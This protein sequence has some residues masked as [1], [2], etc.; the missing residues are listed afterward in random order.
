M[1]GIDY[2]VS[3]GITEDDIKAYVARRDLVSF[4]KFMDVDLELTHFHLVYYAVLNMFAQGK[5]RKLIISAPPQH[6]K[7]EGSTRKLPA[8]LL[9]MNPDEKIAIGSYE[10]TTAQDFNKDVQK[11][12]DSDEYR[13]VFPETR[14]SRGEGMSYNSAFARNSRV[15]EIVGRKGKLMAVGRSRALTSKTVDTSILDDI[16]KDYEEGNSPII[17]EKAWKWYTSVIRK[18]LHN[19]SRELIVF[20][21]WHD[22]DIIGRLE[23]IETVIVP[24][25]W[26]DFDNIPEGA[27]IK[28]NFQAIK[29]DEWSELDPRSQGEALW[30]DRHSIDKLL[31]ERNLD[32]VQFEC[33]NQGNTES[34]ESL[35]YSPFKTYHNSEELGVCIGKGNYT[36]TADEGDDKLCSISYDKIR[37]V[38]EFGKRTYLLAVTDIL[39]TDE[40][41]EK[42][43]RLMPVLYKN[44]DTRYSRIESNN[45]GKAFALIIK[46][47]CKHV[48]ITWFHQSKNKE[49]RI[50]TNAGL[51]NHHIIMPYGWECKWPEFYKVVVRYKR[52][53]SANKYHDASDV[54][55]G[56]IEKEILQEGLR[57]GIRR[58]N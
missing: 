21:R 35:L 57:R 11:I 48:D 42:T 10:S 26:S 20:T 9:G 53:F 58:R 19:N 52:D 14:L 8:F 31:A 37:T 49:S 43:T 17:R 5:I 28:I 29:E 41:I 23:K 22:D 25:K 44:A 30:D 6:G 32:P 39:F 40:P 33:M 16:Y 46:E 50:L 4:S 27:W 3:K 36:D 13:V 34:Q 2:L 12:I 54:L 51:V 38:N 47:A 7:S 18:R 15:F 45:G 24:K 55:T 56:I 1:E